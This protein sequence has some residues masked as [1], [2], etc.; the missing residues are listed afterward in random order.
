MPS[1]KSSNNIKRLRFSLKSWLLGKLSP[2]K[3]TPRQEPKPQED[4]DP[5]SR[6]FTAC[7]QEDFSEREYTTLMPYGHHY[8]EYGTLFILPPPAYT[9]VE[10]ISETAVEESSS[11]VSQDKDEKIET[12]PPMGWAFLYTS[13]IPRMRLTKTERVVLLALLALFLV[14]WWGWF[15]SVG[16]SLV[17]AFG[18]PQAIWYFFGTQGREE[19]AGGDKGA[20]EV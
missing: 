16:A 18:C 15:I 5:E 7:V 14:Y 9:E 6:Y 10:D 13:R 11:S 1:K 12:P 2:S 20:V 3:K 17:I 4:K 19:E 8:D